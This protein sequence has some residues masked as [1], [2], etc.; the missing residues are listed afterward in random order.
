[1]F[2]RVHEDALQIL[3][4]VFKRQLPRLATAPSDDGKGR[5]D[6]R[7]NFVQHIALHYWYTDLDLS[8]GSIMRTLLETADKKYIKELANFVGFRLYKSK[9]TEKEEHIKKLIE[10][11]EAIVEL[12][13]NDNTKLEALE[14]FGTWFASG[15]FDLKWSLEQLTYA[16]SK[17]GNIN[18]DFAA[19]E[20]MEKIAGQY[21]AESIKALSAMVDGTRERWSVSSW[22]SNATAIIQAACN[23]G[24]DSVKQSAKDLANKLV[25]KGYTEYRNIIVGS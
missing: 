8:E 15:K 18:L 23:S 1:M 7:E 6:G 21:P 11:W 24:D 20:Y 14:E 3:G 2:N 17:A 13:K 16:A 9:G 22:S 10:L 12:T 4:D 19:L 5:H 25:A